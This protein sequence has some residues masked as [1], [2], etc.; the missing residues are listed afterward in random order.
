MEPKKV[1]FSRE[2]GI[3]LK[4][5]VYLDTLL[6]FIYKPSFKLRPF[7]LK[8]QYATAKVQRLSCDFT[9]NQSF[10]PVAAPFLKVLISKVPIQKYNKEINK[11]LNIRSILNSILSLYT[12]ISK[13]F[14]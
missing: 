7:T 5:L 2:C 1:V 9:G 3:S 10:V 13:I 14:F 11:F 12:S 4:N 6:S 8:N